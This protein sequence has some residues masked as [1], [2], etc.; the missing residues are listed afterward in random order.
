VNSGEVEDGIDNDANG[1]IDDIRGWDFFS[2]D[3]DP[4]DGSGHGTHTAGTVGAVRDNGI[5]IAGICGRCRLMPLRFL[6]PAGGSTSDAI[7]AID[8]AVANGASVSNNSW[9]GGGYSQALFDA[10]QAAGE[11]GHVF[12]A[13]AGNSGLNTDV[14][15]SYPSSYAL[16]NIISVAATDNLDQL[17]GFSNYG[18]TSVDIGAP[19]VDVA[20][21]YW[22]PTTAEDDYW[23]NSGTS[24]AAPHVT[25]VVALLKEQNA[26]LS[27][28]QLVDR[29]LRS[30]RPVAALVGLTVTGG[31]LNADNAVRGVYPEP[32]PTPPGPPA[33]PTDL[34][35]A[36]STHG[37]ALLAWTG[38][39]DATFYLIEREERRRNGSRIGGTFFQVPAQA[40]VGGA[41]SYE[42]VTG[43]KQYLYYRIAAGNAVG[44]SAM[45]GWVHVSVT[46]GTDSGGGSGPCR[47]KKA[48]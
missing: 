39:A 40:G 47:P 6:G 25:G 10:I 18:A 1:F 20:S 8:Y 4:A 30:A 11:N 37:S 2:D 33:T 22:D 26:D 7:L 27:P 31:V 15:A 32:L 9:G 28:A 23:W 17:A 48:C 19:G 13:A 36:D 5:G 29:V 24:M 35:A 41:E 43:A 44:T 45:S 14:F 3:N 42:D 16:P 38:V 34:S 12:V 21:T 46:D